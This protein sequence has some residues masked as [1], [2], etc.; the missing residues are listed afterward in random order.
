MNEKMKRV[1]LLNKQQQKQDKHGLTYYNPLKMTDDN[2]VRKHLTIYTSSRHQVEFE[3]T[4]WVQ[5]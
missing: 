2:I 1:F 5:V 4:S 3:S